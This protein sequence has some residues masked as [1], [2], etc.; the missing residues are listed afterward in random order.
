MFE[1]WREV[2]YFDN[3]N[4]VFP[5][6]ELLDSLGLYEMDT[7]RVVSKALSDLASDFND[8]LLENGIYDWFYSSCYKKVFVKNDSVLFV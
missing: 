8:V 3:E 2:V 4:A 6:D 1:H 5:S 7:R